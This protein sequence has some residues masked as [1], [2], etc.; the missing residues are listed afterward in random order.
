MN[1]YNSVIQDL[2]SYFS[3]TRLC[4]LSESDLGTFGE[5]PFLFYPLSVEPEFSVQGKC[6]EFNDQRAIIRQMALCLPAGY[7]LVF[8]EHSLLGRRDLSF[9]RELLKFP[10]IRMVHP[11]IRG[12]ELIKKAR[13]VATMAGSA[14]LEASL[15]GKPVVE[16]SVHSTFSFL[17]NIQ[18]VTD[19]HTLPEVLR[20]AM[21]ERS[22]EETEAIKVK[23]ARMPEAIERISFEG[24]ESPFFGKPNPTLSEMEI[25]QVTNLLVDLFNRKLLKTHGE[26][27][28]Q[29]APDLV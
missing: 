8:K 1:F 10:N 23:A 3:Y 26:G 9:Y 25:N 13:A 15:L 6:K 16:F 20:D 7:E 27:G 12:V 22:A 5:K 14:S 2:Y 28:N 19:L 24:S 18:T 11:A 4:K 29:C 21:R 17:P